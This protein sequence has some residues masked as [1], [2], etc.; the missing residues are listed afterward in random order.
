ME[1]YKSG[2]LG[3]V[4]V[5]VCCIAMFR[6][7]YA[8]SQCFYFLKKQQRGVHNVYNDRIVGKPLPEAKLIDFNG[9][10]LG[11]GELRGGKVILV[12][13]S[14]DCEPCFMEGQ[15]LKTLVN[16]YSDL[17]FYGALLSWSDRGVSGVEGKFPMKLFYDQ[18]L[19]LQQALEVRALPLKIL[20]VDGVVK[21]A[22]AGTA[23]NPEAREAFCKDL[24]EVMKSAAPSTTR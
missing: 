13:L 7:S 11:D 23:I 5:A 18:D 12:L 21:K 20:L 4:V 19:L 24:E 10:A 14:S 6:I 16:K 15:F 8:A 22:W 3:W 1:Q 17:R 9:H 2:K